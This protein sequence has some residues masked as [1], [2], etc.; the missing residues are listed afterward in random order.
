M[1]RL[2]QIVIRYSLVFPPIVSLIGSMLSCVPNVIGLATT[3]QIV[4][5]HLVVVTVVLRIIHLRIVPFM[6]KKI[7]LSIDVLIVKMQVRIVRVTRAIG[8]DVL[9]T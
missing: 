2:R 9:P 4:M 3:M 6:V 1:K 8:I 7:S 5:V